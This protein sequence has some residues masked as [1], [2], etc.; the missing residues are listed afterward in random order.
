MNADDDLEFQSFSREV[1]PMRFRKVRPIGVW[2]LVLFFVSL[3]LYFCWMGVVFFELSGAINAGDPFSFANR[4][5]SGQTTYQSFPVQESKIHWDS[6]KQTL[7][8][9]H[10]DWGLL[11]IDPFRPEKEVVASPRFRGR[12]IDMVGSLLLIRDG[13]DGTHI[14]HAI[15]GNQITA[16]PISGLSGVSKLSPNGMRIA[17]KV[18]GIHDAKYRGR[19]IHLLTQ[20][21]ENE[22][23]IEHEIT[24]D[25]A[26]NEISDWSETNSL[27]AIT[28]WSKG[29]LHFRIVDANTG[30]IIKESKNSAIECTDRVIWSNDASM[31]FYMGSSFEE[32]NWDLYVE[33][34]IN[35]EVI[36]ITDTPDIDEISP[37]LSPD[38]TRLV[39]IARYW[40]D[41]NQPAQ[42]L[43]I[44]EFDGAGGL[45]KPVK[46][47][48]NRNELVFNPIWI[49]NSEIVYMVWHSD[50]EESWEFRKIHAGT[51][52]SE[53]IGIFYPPKIE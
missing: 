46:L 17:T 16:A 36:Q 6:S 40:H 37:S 9:Y 38:Q 22:W 45:R 7:L 26:I 23:S 28:E 32:Q 27:I 47:T 35:E 10:N 48:E 25:K 29:G 43:F 19:I 42:E 8:V 1:F 44:V 52:S 3:T 2:L 4:I 5:C 51:L 24:F 21:D 39:Y 34:L 30:T 53:T 31:L 49:S 41:E 12:I 20:R 33:H 11:I 14:Y 13:S 15:N 50:G 18:M